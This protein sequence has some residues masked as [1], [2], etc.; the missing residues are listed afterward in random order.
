MAEAVPLNI[1]R[2]WISECGR[3]RV[4]LSERSIANMLHMARRALP[5]E[6][7]TSLMGY[8][9]ADGFTAFVEDLAPMARDSES[10]R[11][12][13]VRGVAGLKQYFLSLFEGSE[14]ARHYVG[15]WHSHPNGIAEPSRVDDE[16]QAAIACDTATKCP[17]VILVV[18]AGNLSKNPEIGVWV[19]SRQR[20]RIDL[21]PD[22]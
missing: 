22:H 3:Y 1:A 4:I 18:L 7:G 14:G 8:Y 2:S 13:F 11:R 19:Y 21:R 20:G 10:Y 15:E 16:S 6:V 5:G 12:S 9:S 17:E